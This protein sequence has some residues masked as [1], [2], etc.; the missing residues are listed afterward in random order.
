[1]RKIFVITLC[2]I[3]AMMTLAGCGEKTTK[4]EVA[5]SDVKINGKEFTLPCT[6]AEL[7]NS[8]VYIARKSAKQEII[9]TEKQE[10]VMIELTSNS[11]GEGEQLKAMIS[12]GDDHKKKEENCFITKIVNESVGADLFTVGD[13]VGL[14]S[15]VKD[16]KKLFRKKDYKLIKESKDEKEGLTQLNYFED[17][18]GR[19]MYFQDDK[20]MYIEVWGEIEKEAVDI[21]D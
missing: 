6:L 8:G 4:K 15:S 17:N 18:K 3:M 7:E 1:M 5:L 12:T 19:V 9:N 20:C 11:F 13:S 16:A 14:D 10:F 2:V 21:V